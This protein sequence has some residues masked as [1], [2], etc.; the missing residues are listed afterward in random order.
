[1]NNDKM[2][3]KIDTVIEA[4]RGKQA[5]DL[6]SLKVGDVIT[7]TQYFILCHGTS[8][9]HVEAITE[10]INKKLK[11]AG[12]DLY[13]VEGEENAEWILIDLS[14]V[15]VHIFTEEKREFYDL[16]GLWGKVETKHYEDE[17]GAK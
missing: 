12:F 8:T 1:M 6:M 10:D 7:F 2:Q 5:K 3:E 4:A 11:K 9:R 13:G 14:D 16:E 15:V 17:E